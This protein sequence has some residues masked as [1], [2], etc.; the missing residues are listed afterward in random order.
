MKRFVISRT[1]E[2]GVHM[3][4]NSFN[5][6]DGLYRVRRPDAPLSIRYRSGDFR[7]PVAGRR[8]AG[9]RM[10]RQNKVQ[11][12]TLSQR[13]AAATATQSHGQDLAGL[14]QPR[15]LGVTA[16]PGVERTRTCTSRS[17]TALA[18]GLRPVLTRVV[19]VSGCRRP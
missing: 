14:E 19:Q 2:P 11:P 18:L 9:N 16:A 3:R 10:A 15:A 6:P 12:G 4:S 17:T 7:F 1:N 13:D 5:L 8:A